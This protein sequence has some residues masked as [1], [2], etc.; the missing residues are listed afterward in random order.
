MSIVLRPKKLPETTHGDIGGE[1]LGRVYP[2]FYVFIVL[3]PF[4]IQ[5]II[6]TFPF[7]SPLFYVKEKL[8]FLISL[9]KKPTDEVG[10]KSIVA[11]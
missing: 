6:P 7:P 11:L 3:L 4:F 2:L 8:Y 9:S 1:G 10:N 5:L